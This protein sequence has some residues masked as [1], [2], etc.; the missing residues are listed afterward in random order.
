MGLWSKQS[1][2]ACRQHVCRIVSSYCVHFRRQ[3]VVHAE[4][5]AAQPR[6]VGGSGRWNVI[7]AET[8]ATSL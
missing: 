2:R 7:A 4:R 6:Q 5:S 3:T 8:N 1:C